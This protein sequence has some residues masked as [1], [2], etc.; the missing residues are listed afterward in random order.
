MYN[1]CMIPCASLSLL[2]YTSTALYHP[3][4]RLTRSVGKASE[5]KSKGSVFE[6]HVRL[7]LYLKLKKLSTT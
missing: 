1:S 6:S 4:I 3:C 2:V 5:Q 7:T